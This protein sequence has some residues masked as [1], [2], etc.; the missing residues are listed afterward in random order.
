MFKTTF[1]V[2]F[3]HWTDVYR[4]LWLTKKTLSDQEYFLS[5][6]P[7]EAENITAAQ[8]LPGDYSC[9]CNFTRQW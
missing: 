2:T 3:S 4:L 5:T 1:W 9:I 7:D 6:L 8:L